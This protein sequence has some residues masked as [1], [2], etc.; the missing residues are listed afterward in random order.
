MLI[1]GVV[2]NM[3]GAE[4]AHRGAPRASSRARTSSSRSGRNELEEK[5][6]LLEVKN[7]EIAAGQ[8]LARGEGEAAR[9][10]LEVQV[11]VPRQHVA[12]APDAAQQHAHPGARCSRRTTSRTSRRKQVEYARTIH[13]AGHD[14]LALINQILDLSKIE[15]GKLQIETH[16][17]PARRAC[18]TTSSGTFR[19]GRA[20]RRTLEF[21]DRDRRR[22]A[23]RRSPPIAQRLAA[24]PQEPAL[25]RVQVHRDGPG[26]AARSSG[27]PTRHRSSRATSLR[28]ARGVVAFAVSDTGHRH[29]R[30]TSSSS[31]SR[32][33]SR[34]T[35]RPAACTAARASASPS[36]ASSRACSAAR[37]TS[38]STPGVGS[39]FTL[40]L[41]L[42]GRGRSRSRRP[43]ERAATTVDVRRAG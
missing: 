3:I 2:F 23:R 17:G 4:H 32:R 14:L 9:A 5:A 37:S 33:S 38:T 13:S 6:T 16:R 36:A 39:T 34:P 25:E 11:R 26:R 22:R 12:R 27:A 1:I 29:R 18:A 10:G 28:R 21:D 42:D 30:R 43:E 15:A 35:P 40:Y 19:P 24:D 20:S 41:P 7:R 8:R 31:S